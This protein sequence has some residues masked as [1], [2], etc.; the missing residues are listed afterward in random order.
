MDEAVWSALSS[1]WRGVASEHGSAEALARLCVQ[2]GHRTDVPS[3]LFL[4]DEA[5]T[6]SPSSKAAL[7]LLE[8]R[9]PDEGRRALWERY[10][11]FL[12]H[13]ATA[14][15]AADV[16]ERLVALL[17]ELGHSYS[18]LVEVDAQLASL[19]PE[20]LTD[21]AIDA[22]YQALLAEDES[23]GDDEAAVLS[24]AQYRRPPFEAPDLAD[25]AE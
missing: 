9:T 3:A 17:F 20:S 13:A 10:E 24:L 23:A 18:A 15:D 11:R 12:A 19:V 25:A 1:W 4:A 22:A 6:L 16:R 7:G 5:L 14:S 21:D 8:R 2:L